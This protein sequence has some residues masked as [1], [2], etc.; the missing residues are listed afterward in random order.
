MVSTPSF[1]KTPVTEAPQRKIGAFRIDW[2]FC[3][4][5]RNMKLIRRFVTET[6]AGCGAT[7]STFWVI[8]ADGKRIE[9]AINSGQEFAKIES[10][11]VHANDSVVG[12][13]ATTGI[14]ACIGPGDFQNPEAKKKYGVKNMV[15][16]PVVIESQICGVLTA[17][18]FVEET[19]FSPEN[20]ETLQWKSY[21]LG[22]VLAN[23]LKEDD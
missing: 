20:L 12:L 21:L 15:V 8:S 23:L 11:V 2:Q 3:H 14:S 17:V 1:D 13:I 5:Y 16:A 19:K 9:G 4:D 18:N 10:E 7:E 6:A 22:L